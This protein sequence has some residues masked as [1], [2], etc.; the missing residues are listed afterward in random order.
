VIPPL[1]GRNT[2]WPGAALA[3]VGSAGVAAAWVAVAML[4]ASQCGWMAVIAA[5]DAAW[6]LRLA[7]VPSGSLRMTIGIGATVLAIVLAQWGIV[8]AHLSGMLGLSFTD[9]ALR[10]GPALAWTLA[11]LANGP[12]DLA[13]IAIGLVVAAIAS[14]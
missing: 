8:S 9:T 13:W 10:L 5:L 6:L 14:R 12:L 4:G 11:G 1:E 3:L 2:A 7:R